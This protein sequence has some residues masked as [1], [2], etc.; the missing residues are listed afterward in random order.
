MVGTSR[1]FGD[2]G[3][4]GVIDNV[5]G[6]LRHVANDLGVIRLPDSITWVACDR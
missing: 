2:C 6:L 3:R 1:G 4:P 5:R